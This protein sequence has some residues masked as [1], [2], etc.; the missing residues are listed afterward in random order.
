MIWLRQKL[1]PGHGGKTQ[2]AEAIHVK[3]TSYVRYEIAVT[4]GP[5]IISRI[6]L[7][8]SVN[9]RWLLWGI[10][11]PFAP[12]GQDDAGNVNAPNVIRELYED[13]ERRGP[14]SVADVGRV[15]LPIRGRASAAGVRRIAYTD[16][17]DLGRDRLPA[18]LHEIQV[19][20]D[21]M[22]PLALEG[23][24]LLVTNAAPKSGDIAVVERIDMEELLFKRVQIEPPSV[25]CVSVN[26]DPHYPV[27][28]IP[29]KLIRRMRKVWGVKF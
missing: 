23:Q 19:I 28:T 5:K 3:L 18:D 25:L 10:G 21:S 1:F 20:G 9:P 14:I 27:L 26:P 16:H 2:F 29:L 4:P 7:A 12:G 6:V 24:F 17:G 8:T 15:F 11:E 22:S 13:T